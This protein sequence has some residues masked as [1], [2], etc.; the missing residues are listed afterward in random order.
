MRLHGVFKIIY[1][2]FTAQLLACS[3][4]AGN[5]PIVRNGQGL[6]YIL[7]PPNAHTIEK[8]AAEDFQWAIKESSG[9]TLQILD[10]PHSSKKLVPVK[11]GLSAI[12]K[13][14]STYKTGSDDWDSLSYDGA[15]IQAQPDGINIA[16]PT[17]MGTSNAVATIL[18]EDIGIRTYYP[19][20]LFTIVPKTKNITIRSRIANP[21]FYYHVWS[22]LTGED[23]AKYKRRN[24]LANSQIPV[25]YFGFGHNLDRIIPVKKY[26]ETH[27]EYFALRDGV[28]Q[29][30]CEGTASAAQPCSTNPDV[31]KLTIEAARDFF[32]KH[33]HNNTFSLCGND[34]VKYCECENCAAMDKPYRKPAIGK[35]YSESYYNYVSK[36]AA[37]IAESH[38]D[39]YLGLYAYWNVEQPPRDREKLP[40]N[41]IAALTLDILQHYNPAYKKKDYKLLK[42]WDKYVDRLHVYVY[43][44][45]GLYTPRTSPML[46]AEHIRFAEKNGVRA[47]YC[48]AYPFWAWCGPMNYVSAR[49]QWDVNEDVEQI[50]TEFHQD[51]FKE[52]ARQMRAYH[53]TC[54]KYWT[55]P[56][57][58]Y[59]FEGLDNLTPEEK[60]A[61]VTIL[62]KAQ[63]HLHQALEKAKDPQV[64]LRILWLKKGF[65]FTMAVAKAFEAKRST[66]EPE[67]KL[68]GL[69]A[70]AQTVEKAHKILIEEPAYRHTYYAPGDRFNRKCWGWFESAM[71]PAVKA[72]RKS[73]QDKYTGTELKI[74]WENFKQHSGLKELMDEHKWDF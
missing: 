19:H 12:P 6:A 10:K 8:K 48:E 70:A 39:R 68:K 16:G 67:Q 11:I 3:V 40:D 27:P 57:K 35:Q 29:V 69:I 73:L 14:N 22:G 61:D 52:V 13:T 21:S 74:Q 54:E 30:D 42:V 47:I 31:I 50:L 49:L 4:F 51:C 26:R 53:D 23:V 2:I 62:Y 7:L 43:Y 28:R 45:L 72:Y 15:I 1:P 36:V 63:G 24:R 66:A 60:M 64:R 9:I 55:R 32:D 18:M 25:P 44:G 46:A 59:W 5:I 37:A 38:P 20:P 71:R 41:V 56:R 58:A 34:N 33:P 17:P 65:D